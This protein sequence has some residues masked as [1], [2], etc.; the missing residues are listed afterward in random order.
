[1]N[2]WIE[3]LIEKVENVIYLA[4]ALILFAIAGVII[5]KTALSFSDLGGG[6]VVDVSAEI[7]DLLLLVFIV[8]ELL[9]AV[10]TTLSR[11]ELVAEPFLLVGIIAS[12]KEIVVLSVKAP[13][14]L[15]KPEFADTVRLM[16][17]LTGTIIVLALS[18]FLLRRKEREPSEGAN[19]GNG[20]D[21]VEE[22]VDG[23]DENDREHRASAGKA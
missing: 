16:A 1:M 22:D 20:E 10:R 2:E 4:V 21:E 23:E 3:R 11:R 14:L 9:F 5:V 18:S 19:S 12:I 13:D 8:V 15:G 17:L 6:S 7:L